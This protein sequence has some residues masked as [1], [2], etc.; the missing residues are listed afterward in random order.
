MRPGMLRS[1]VIDTI[2]HRVL[3]PVLHVRLDRS[4]LK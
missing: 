1:L 3:L 2:R 4:H